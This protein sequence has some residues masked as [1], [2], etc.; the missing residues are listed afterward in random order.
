M[1]SHLCMV[2]KMG[3]LGI[4]VT[5]PRGLS[6][7]VSLSLF[8]IHRSQIKMSL[9]TTRLLCVRVCVCMYVFF[10]IYMVYCLSHHSGNTTS[11]TVISVDMY[12]I[13]TIISVNMCTY[14]VILHLI[15]QVQLFGYSTILTINLVNV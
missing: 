6:L 13:F 15:C 12:T 9:V 5:C 3:A 4:R 10:N 14:L 11:F 1:V 7:A 2:S 8:V